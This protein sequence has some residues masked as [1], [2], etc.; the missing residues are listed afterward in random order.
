M[1]LLIAEVKLYNWGNQIEYKDT[2]KFKFNRTLTRSRNKIATMHLNK[3]FPSVRKAI[4]STLQ[5]RVI[6]VQMSHPLTE[7]DSWQS[8]IFI[9]NWFLRCHSFNVVCISNTTFFQ[10]WWLCHTEALQPLSLISLKRRI[11]NQ[12]WWSLMTWHHPQRWPK[13]QGQ[14]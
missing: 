12:T 14:S 6:C 10:N 9:V 7:P 1:E 4:Y 3:I 8:T 5:L 2:V 11:N 13:T